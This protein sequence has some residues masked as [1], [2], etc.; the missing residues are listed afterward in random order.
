MT[1]AVH[2]PNLQQRV[3]RAAPIQCSRKV[4]PTHGP[5][6]LGAA[7]DRM[8]AGSLEWFRKPFALDGWT[9]LS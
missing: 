5:P 3:A 4:P 1:A 6:F 9:T 2:G 7:D 8:G